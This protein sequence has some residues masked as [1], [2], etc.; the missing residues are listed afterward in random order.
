[1]LTEFG[2]FLRILRISRN[3][4]AKQMSDVL[5][6]SNSYLSA[7]ENGKRNIPPSW[8]EIIVREYGLDDSA[9]QELREAISR[10]SMKINVDL[11]NV[12]D[13]RKNFYIL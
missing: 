1:M 7:V 11:S 5:G 8:E 12:T 13:K 6:V 9:K 10:S 3:Q 4:S 2:K